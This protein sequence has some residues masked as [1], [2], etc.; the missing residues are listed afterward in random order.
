MILLK[1]MQKHFTKE[2]QKN[3]TMFQ[4][5]LCFDWKMHEEFEKLI[6]NG[7]KEA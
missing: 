4:N 7:Y 5:I 2:L 1:W 6:E 3:Q